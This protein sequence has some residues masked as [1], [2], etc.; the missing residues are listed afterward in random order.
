MTSGG[1]LKAGKKCESAEMISLQSVESNYKAVNCRPDESNVQSWG[2]SGR[3]N[4]PSFTIF[5]WVTKQSKY[6]F[7]L[8]LQLRKL[9]LPTI[10]NS[11]D[12]EQYHRI[13]SFNPS[14]SAL[15]ANIFKL[16]I[17]FLYILNW[18]FALLM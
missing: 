16:K 1:L 5:F 11:R 8:K 12:V 6:I 4:V 7:M 3:G 2:F 13:H 14:K 10:K 15:K 9:L 17:D 18:Y